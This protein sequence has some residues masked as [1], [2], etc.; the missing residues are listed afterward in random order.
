MEQLS[1]VSA[2]PRNGIVYVG[3]QGGAA[4]NPIYR[5]LD[6]RTQSNVLTG[7]VM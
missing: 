7:I 1:L 5:T 4:V 2:L 3:L 6:A